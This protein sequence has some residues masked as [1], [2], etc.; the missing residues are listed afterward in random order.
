MFICKFGT[1]IHPLKETI[2]KRARK[3]GMILYGLQPLGSIVLDSGACG[4]TFSSSYASLILLIPVSN[5]RRSNIT[6]GLAFCLWG[7]QSRRFIS[8]AQLRH[9]SEWERT[10][11]CAG[12]VQLFKR[13]DW[14][15]QR[16]F[17][18]K[19]S[20]CAWLP[21]NERNCFKRKHSHPVITGM[22]G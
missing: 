5:I 14:C 19:A 15:H 4:C 22:N 12:F 3:K 1:V 11:N 8:R 20:R 13:A 6:E 21:W 2:S 7:R 17:E 10:G 9:D 16:P 18:Q